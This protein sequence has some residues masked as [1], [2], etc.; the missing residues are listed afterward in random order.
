MESLK[1]SH[2]DYRTQSHFQ[3]VRVAELESLVQHKTAQLEQKHNDY[4]N[5]EEK[6]K[7]LS[8]QIVSLKNDME[9]MEEMMTCRG[10][11]LFKGLFTGYIKCT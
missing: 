1:K 6:A 8:C 3:S 4:L 2:E 10:K 11:Y 5:S 9:E 7:N